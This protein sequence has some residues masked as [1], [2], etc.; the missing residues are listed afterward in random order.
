MNQGGS[1]AASL[2]CTLAAVFCKLEAV[3]DLLTSSFHAEDR[4]EYM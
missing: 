3:S 1:T 4:T 2:C